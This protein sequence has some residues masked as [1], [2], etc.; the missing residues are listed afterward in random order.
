[1]ANKNAHIM[2]VIKR[3][4]RSEKNTGNSHC[5]TKLF[6]ILA[7]NTACEAHRHKHRN[8]GS[9]NRNHSKANFTGRVFRGFIGAFPIFIWR[10]TFS[11]STITSSTRIPVTS[12]MPSSE[13]R[14]S[15]KPIVSNTQKVGMIKARQQQQSALH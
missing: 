3:A 12:V 7:R 9:R 2:G 15:E 4:T 6:E 8:N 5:D 11:I 10:I 13:T 14:L 1:M